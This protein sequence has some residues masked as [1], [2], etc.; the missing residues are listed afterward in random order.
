[1]VVI[2]SGPNGLAAAVTMARAG[3]IVTVHEQAATMGGGARSQ[4]LTL[5]GFVHDTCSAVHPLAAASPF[6]RSL[7]LG[8]HG[9]DWIE[10]DVAVAHPLADGTAVA[11]HRSVRRTAES[12]GADAA[13]YRRLVQPLV[14][15]WSRLLPTLLAPPLRVPR[16]PLAASR[17]GLRGL[18]SARGLAERVFEGERARALFGGLAAHSVLPLE[19]AGTAAVGLVFALTA[20]AGGWP[21]PRG[22]SQSIADALAA[23]LRAHGG[24][25]HVESRVDSLDGLSDATVLCDVGPG[26]LLRLAGKRIRDGRYRRR[27][28]AWRYGPGVFKVDWALDGPI[29]WV[30]PECRRAGTVH[31]G[32]TLAEVADA[33][34]AAWEGRHAERP[35]VLLAQPSL[36]DA[37]RAPAGKHTAWAYCHVPNGSAEDMTDRIEAQVERFAPGFR[38]LVLARS[39]RGPAELERENPNLVGGD[40]TGGA[41]QLGQLLAR[42]VLR[43]DPFATPVPGVYLC[44]SSTPPGPGVHGMCGYWAARSAL[45]AL[46]R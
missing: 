20:H 27:L 1:V 42:P 8:A 29:P 33:E 32:G 45:R 13:A 18:R 22:G 37:S 36:I 2:G 28:E 26:G 12:L 10:A 24:E 44:S 34:R 14:D 38:A 21:I 19:R 46:G 39:T 43:R 41:M 31:V 35:F 4:E 7:P 5:H 30:A 40:I 25:V 11:L 17:F 23:E 9:L 16:H 15:D 6:F 3:L